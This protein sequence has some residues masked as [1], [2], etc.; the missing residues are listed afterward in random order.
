LALR[1]ARQTAALAPQAGGV[2]SPDLAGALDTLRIAI[3]IFDSSERLIFSNEH[4]NYLFRSLP[5]REELVGLSYEE[6]IR[7]ELM[8]GET[9]PGADVEAYVARRREQ[10]HDGEYRPRDIRLADGRIVEI[11][12]RRTP[13]G[14]WIVL[15]TDATHARHLNGRLESA[16]ELSADAFAFF[17]FSDRLVMCNSGFAHLHGHEEPESLVGRTAPDIVEDA[18]RRGLFR[19]EGQLAEWLEQRSEAH[20]SPAGAMTLVTASGTA[21][22]V[23]ERATPDGR[24]TVFTDVTD[25]RRVENALVEQTR[26]LE[27]TRRAL[28]QTQ[29]EARR[30]AT[31]LADLT[32][33]LDRAEAEADTTKN[34]LL[35]TMSHELKT[36]LNAIIGFSDLLLALAERASPE[37]VREYAGLIHQGGNNLLRL[38]NQILDLTKLAAGRYELQSV[39]IDSGFALQTVADSYAARA[40]TKAIAISTAACPQGILTLADENAL[41]AMLDHLIGNAVGFIQDGGTVRLS[42]L[43]AADRVHIAVSDNGP[44]V[45]RADIPRILRPFEQIGR[46]TTDHT[47]GAGLGLTLVKA[48]VELH[49]GRLR[50]ESALGEGFTATLDLPA[51]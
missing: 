20:N 37:Q 49:G 2:D 15:W 1:L 28:S 13:E 26:A 32:K 38:L 14:G 16:I 6:L 36:P 19:I 4:F 35:R 5:P 48:F 24:V 29:D 25:S 7:L 11:K 45:A 44:G 12:A 30:Q 47:A 42:T 31:Y 8:G 40:K 34:T 39:P 22:L 27:R 21:F 50:I 10:F 41:R 43:R 33:K 51:A 23:R 17:D 3:T 18:G 46:S 9:A